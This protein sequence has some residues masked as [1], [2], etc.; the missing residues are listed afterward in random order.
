MASTL[1]RWDPWQDLA[2]FRQTMDRLFDD[3]FNG[4][5]NGDNGRGG[6]S[7]GMDIIENAD[8]FILKA[9]VPGVKPADVEI[10]VENDVL[11]LRGSHR[12][13]ERSDSD[14]YLRRELHW[15]SFERSMRLPPTVDAENAQASFEDGILTLT[16]PKRPEAKPRSIKITPRESAGMIDSSASQS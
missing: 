5:S 13:E 9:A 10:N 4:M 16:L 2:N 3:T 11:T 12:E 14:N 15:G 8:N 6:Y 7:V 1:V